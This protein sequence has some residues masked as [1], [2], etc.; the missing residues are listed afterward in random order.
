LVNTILLVSSSVTITIAHHA[1]RKGHRGALK[2]WLA[3]TVFLGLA[4]LGFQAEEY[5]HAYKELGL[6]TKVDQLAGEVSALRS[7]QTKLATDVQEAKSEAIRANQ[8]L[9]N[10]ATHYK[11]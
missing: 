8:R 10:M 1:L 9:D 6:T 11:K 2:I 4:F 3:I 5:I 7:E